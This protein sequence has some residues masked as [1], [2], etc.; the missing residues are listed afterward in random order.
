MGGSTKDSFTVRVADT[1]PPAIDTPRDLLAFGKSD[2]AIV[3]Y[4]VAAKDA[5]NGAMDVACFPASGSLF[6]PGQTIVNCSSSDKTR[7]LAKGSFLVTVLPWVDETEY[8]AGEGT[9]WQ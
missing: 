7:N 6:A 9:S 5:V 4:D 3:T 2:G 1:Q 8:L